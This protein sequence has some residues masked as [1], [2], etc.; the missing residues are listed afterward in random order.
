MYTVAEGTVDEHVADTLLD[1]LEQ[2]V[3][4]ID[5]PT[6]VGI[7]DTLGSTEDADAIIQSVFDLFGG[8]DE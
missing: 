5:D 8:S 2:V 7:A 1:K 3:N 6:A 4:T